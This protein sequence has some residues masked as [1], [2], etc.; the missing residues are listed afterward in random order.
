MDTRFQLLILIINLSLLIAVWQLT[1]RGIFRPAYA[2]LWLFT[3]A[4]FLILT[5]FRGVVL[6]LAEVA[7][8]GYPPSILFATGIFFIVLILIAQTAIVSDFSRKNKELAQNYAL[9]QWRVE[10]LERQL[11]NEEEIKE[12]QVTQLL[13]SEGELPSKEPIPSNLVLQEKILMASGVQTK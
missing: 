9:L 4:V 10:Q 6:Y 1:K 8:V 5:L 13:T 7:N 2:L 3:S 11:K 12:N